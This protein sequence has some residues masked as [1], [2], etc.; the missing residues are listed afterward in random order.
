MSETG[1][2]P[3]F[4][5]MLSVARNTPVGAHAYIGTEGLPMNVEC[6]GGSVDDVGVSHDRFSGLFNQVVGSCPGCCASLV[7]MREQHRWMTEQSYRELLRSP[8]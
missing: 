1:G 7:W 2:Y 6:S 4:E 8:Q 3:D 5:A